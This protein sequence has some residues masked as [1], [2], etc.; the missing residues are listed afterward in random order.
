MNRAKR[1]SQFAIAKAAGVS[2]ATVSLALR[3]GEGLAPETVEKVRSAAKRMGYRPNALVEGIKSGKTSTIGLFLHPW[4]SFWNEVIN[5]ICD[6]L[7]EAEHVPVLFLDKTRAMGKDEKHALRL[8]HRALDQWCDAVILWPYFAA[9]YASHVEEF[10]F[11][12]VPVVT[13]DHT[14]PERFR[15]DAI[16][17]NEMEVA[18]LVLNHLTSLGHER[19]LLVGGPQGTGWADERMAAFDAHL[20]LNPSLKAESVRIS[21]SD[22]AVR[23]VLER[24]RRS[25][26]PTAVVAGTDHYAAAAYQAACLAGLSIPKD[27]SITGVADLNFA[28]LLSPPLTTVRQNGY[29]TGRLAAQVA[30]ERSVG[31]L[32]GAPVEHRLP[33]AFVERAST[34]RAPFYEKEAQLLKS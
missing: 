12:N 14:L 17:T 23:P 20:A 10:S 29:E 11:R 18:G 6:R 13:I 26:R 1:P 25:P 8:V 28:P 9:L 21:E 27:L 3:G 30:L 16:V 34:A 22:N 19:L 31:I 5:G 2:R 24:L 7:A 4:D 32:R 33:V 15:A